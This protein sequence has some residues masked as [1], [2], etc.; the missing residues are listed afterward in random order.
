MPGTA[1][2]PAEVTHV[3]SGGFGLRIDD[4]ELFVSFE[5][6]PWFRSATADQIRHVERPHVRHLR[7]PDLDVDLTVESIEHPDRYPLRSAL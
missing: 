4:R 3:T 2:S 6:F 1:I 5:E 7:W